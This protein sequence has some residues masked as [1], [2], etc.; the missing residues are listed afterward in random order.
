[1]AALTSSAVV[2]PAAFQAAVQ[3]SG[4][5]SK[6]M[7]FSGLKAG[8]AKTSEFAAKTV[9]N[10]SRVSCMKVWS[11][12]NN[13]RF[14]TLSYLPA[15]TDD[16]IAKE[17]RYMLSK[18]WVPCL[19]FD[20]SGVVFR[21]NNSGPGYYDGRYWT[22]WKLPLF[23]CTDASQVLRELAECKAAYPQCYIR[24]LGFDNVQQVQ[25]MSFIAHKP[26]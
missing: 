20:P 14:E 10:S 17:I 18:G 12:I 26:F 25:C 24:V 1:M 2:A 6:A 4:A 11:P 9:S 23:G 21:E 8:V 13:P 16:M 5:A 19:E 7:S 3:S 15:L 22:M